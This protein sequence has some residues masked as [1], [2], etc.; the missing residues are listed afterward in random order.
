MKTPSSLL[1][2]CSVLLTTGWLSDRLPAG[3]G[4]QPDLTSTESKSSPSVSGTISDPTGKPIAGVIVRMF[5][6]WG[7]SSSEKEIKTDKNGHYDLAWTFPNFGG[8]HPDFSLVAV[9]KEKSLAATGGLDESTR[10][11]DLQ[12]QP[13]L[14]IIGEV[15]DEQGRPLSGATASATL[16][17]GN[18]GSQFGDQARTSSNGMFRISCLPADRRYSITV[19]AE[20]YGSSYQSVEDNGES[21]VVR[22]TPFVLKVADQVVAGQVLDENEKPA[23]SANVNVQGDGQPNTSMTADSSG[24]FKVKV[25]A[26]TVRIYVNTQNAYA[27]SSVEAGDT[28]VV[29]QVHSYSNDRNKARRASLKGQRLPDLASLGLATQAAQSKGPLLICLFD[30]DQRPSR[31]VLR[32]LAERNEVLTKRN[33]VVLAAQAR[34]TTDASLREWKESNPLPFAVGQLSALTNET[35]WATEVES[36]PWLILT[37]SERTVV[38]EGFSPDDLETVLQGVVK[39]P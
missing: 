12:L 15:Q 9:V 22:L 28:N 34:V 3:A 23:A 20:G 1:F 36:L 2:W 7:F 30:A 19:S 18:M 37:D 11:L 4:A 10:N 21:N 24:R 27:N 14:A 31:R 29:L 32:S 26:G 33:V 39:Q 16:W 35:K 38:E 6:D 8:S 17:A 13:A 5:P 25:C